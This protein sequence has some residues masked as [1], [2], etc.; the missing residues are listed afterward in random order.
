MMRGYADAPAVIIA[1]LYFLSLFL[2][3]VVIDLL[4]LFAHA[5]LRDG[6]EFP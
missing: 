5:V 2:Q 3:R 1:W 6:V 4:G